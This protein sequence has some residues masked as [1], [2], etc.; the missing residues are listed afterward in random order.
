MKFHTSTAFGRKK[1]SRKSGSKKKTSPTR[2]N[3]EK[4]AVDPGLDAPGDGCHSTFGK[5][6]Q[7]FGVA[8]AG[9]VTSEHEGT[10]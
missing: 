8:A 3:R 9:P 5:K 6:L 2:R 1:R 4:V 7:L 10:L